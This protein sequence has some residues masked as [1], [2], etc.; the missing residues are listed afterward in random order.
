VSELAA[1]LDGPDGLEGPDRLNRSNHLNRVLDALIPPT[2]T[3]PGGSV[4]APGLLANADVAAVLAGLPAP[5]AGASGP[6]AAWERLMEADPRG[7]GTVLHVLS[8]AYFALPAV[9]AAYGLA[10]V[11]RP[12]EQRERLA[13]LLADVP[14]APGLPARPQPPPEPE[15]AHPVPPSSVPPRSQESP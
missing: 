6:P 4:A 11:R 13:A 3:L 10:R 1:G 7:A 5:A 9:R 14:P 12:P 2:G 8:A 15:P